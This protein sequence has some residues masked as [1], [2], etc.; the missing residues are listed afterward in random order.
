MLLAKRAARLPSVPTRLL[1]AVFH[2]IPAAWVVPRVE[3]AE[4]LSSALFPAAPL[5]P[6]Q[7]RP[8]SRPELQA[9]TEARRLQSGAG[10]QR[11]GSAE[12]SPLT[13][14][15]VP[16]SWQEVRGGTESKHSGGLQSETARDLLWPGATTTLDCP[17]APWGPRW[18]PGVCLFESV[19]GLCRD[20]CRC[21]RIHALRVSLWHSRERA[22]RGSKRMHPALAPCL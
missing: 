9:V 8:T 18:R 11:Y 13:Y 22:L 10:W 15:R 2:S 16:P 6:P 4:L 14:F 7:P 21:T 12:G 3:R 17:A 19:A 5:G 20:L 1:P